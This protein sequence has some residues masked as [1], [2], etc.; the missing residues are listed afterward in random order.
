MIFQLLQVHVITARKRSL[1]RLCFYTCLSVCPQRGVC[2]SACC[3]AHTP[4]PEAGTPP[5]PEAGSPQNQRQAPP[6][7]EQCMLRDTGNKRAVRILLECILVK[8]S[9]RTLIRKCL[10]FVDKTLHHMSGGIFLLV[11]PSR[12]ERHLDVDEPPVLIFL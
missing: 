2:P 5:R 3:D 12:E 9:L 6:P 10:T 1:R 4:G 8:D 7:R 11:P